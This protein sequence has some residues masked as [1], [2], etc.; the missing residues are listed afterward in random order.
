MILDLAQEGKWTVR[1][2]W[3]V[4]TNAMDKTSFQQLKTLKPKEARR[5]DL[6][7][8]RNPAR[9]PLNRVRVWK[10]TMRSGSTRPLPLIRLK[11]DAKMMVIDKKRTSSPGCTGLPYPWGPLALIAACLVFVVFPFSFCWCF[12]VAMFVRPLLFCV[13]WFLH[14]QLGFD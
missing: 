7:S 3:L 9:S 4:R 11:E 12:C 10:E 14:R 8:C 5:Q 13:F 1:L 6:R 2:Y